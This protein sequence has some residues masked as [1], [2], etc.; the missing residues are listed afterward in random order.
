MVE[1]VDQLKSITETLG[2]LTTMKNY[3]MSTWKTTNLKVLQSKFTSFLQDEKKK[4]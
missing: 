2:D 3:L 4:K 1:I